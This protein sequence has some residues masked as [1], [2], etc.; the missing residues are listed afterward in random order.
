MS[1]PIAVQ[2]YSLREEIQTDLA[3][4]IRKLADIGYV[5]VEPFGDRRQELVFIGEKLDVKGI[6]RELDN[7]LLKDEEWKEWQA[8][9]MEG[10]GP[11]DGDSDEREAKFDRLAEVFEDGFP[12]WVEDEEDDHG[13]DHTGH[14]H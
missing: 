13:H 3:G 7:C 8:I 5:G 14:H 4:V 10:A 12:D 11:N 6:E 1:A 9:M 2:L